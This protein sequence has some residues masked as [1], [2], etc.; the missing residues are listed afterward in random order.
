MFPTGISSNAAHLDY[1]RHIAG[2]DECVGKIL[3]ALDELR[4]ADDT[5][6]VYTSDNGYYLGEHCSGDKRS[7]YEESL[8][9]PMLVRYPREFA[10]GKRVDEMVLNIDLAPTLLDLAGIAAPAEMQ[11]A[12]WRGLAAG[13]GA[14]NWRK[15]FL[16][17][18]YKELGNVP[19]TYC[20][21]TTTHKLVKYPD[22]P[23]WTELFDLRSD[24]Y[25]TR[26]LA[27][28]RELS[29]RLGAEL[30]VVMRGVGYTEPVPK[31]D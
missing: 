23:E 5:V 14:A 2:V 16:A 10:R 28:D 22:H 3:A 9:V 19:T 6:V 11:G 15:S 26:N 31:R 25:E 1:L 17:E 29:A 13:R 27:S 20:L 21:R 8:R 7:L 18:Y 24:P 12:S 4:L 30:A